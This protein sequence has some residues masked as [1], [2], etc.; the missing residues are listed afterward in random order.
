MYRRALA[1]AEKTLGPEN[2]NTARSLNNLATLYLYAGKYSQV[3]SLL[4][5]SLTIR[6]KSLGNEHPDVARTLFSLAE[7]YN[8]QGKFDESDSIHL[9]ALSIRK[10]ALP[11][12]HP[13]ISESLET[14]AVLRTRQKKLQSAVQLLESSLGIQERNLTLALSTGSEKRKRDYLATLAKTTDTALW[15]H[16]QVASQD[17]EA[18]RLAMTT[19]LRR[20]GRLL[21]ALSDTNS[22]L[23]QRLEPDEQKLLDELTATRSNLAALVFRGLEDDTP[24]QYRAKVAALE[25]QAEQLETSLS[26]RSAEFVRQSTAVTLDSVRQQLPAD[27][28][29][30]EIVQYRPLNLQAVERDKQFGAARYAAYLLDSQGKL[31]WLDLGEA[32]SLNA[33]ATALRQQ[34]QNS[35]RSAAKLK[36]LARRLEQK[37]MAPIR[38][39]LGNPRRILISPDGMLNLLPF[40]TLIDERNRYLVEN[41]TISYLSSGRDLLRLGRSQPAV[42][43]ALIVAN[44]NFDN[45][46]TARTRSAGE[47]RRRSTEPV[48][49]DLGKL[50][51]DPLPATAEEAEAIA[52]LLP[53][54]RVLTGK[55]ATENALKQVRGPG[56]LHIATHGFFLEEVEEQA[57][58]PLLRSGLVLAG[59]N[60]RDSGGDDGALTA[61]ELSGLNL[62]GTRL[63]VLSAC[64]TGLGEIASGEGVYGLKRALTLAGAESQ[65]VSL[66]QVEDE[67]TRDLMVQY[68]RQLQQGAGRG[69]GL[70]KAQLNLLK[71]KQ[72]SH[73]YYWSSFILSGD[74]R[75]VQGLFQ[76]AAG[77]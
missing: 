19:V 26:R 5:Q 28:A 23:R 45:A 30:V 18:A 20:K 76:S 13:F 14:L 70:R 3:E 64:E 58:N 72:Y 34:L 55:N 77:R 29:L 52:E 16:Q 50:R 57:K 2:P 66:W 11:P 48:A 61:L 37:L 46:E 36:P 68:Y 65:L 35:E 32:T 9:R 60:Q 59:F 6:Q 38:R 31:Q 4:Q 25:T 7:L 1:I 56:I 27:T 73:P 33:A 47:G 49:A 21:D 43:S 8:Y 40:A 41:Y 42:Q 51:Y 53:E 44:P 75:P 63:V 15:L 24:E 69:E 54:A 71:S 10:K 67:G 74:W 17:T 39:K 62:Q 12:D 22:A